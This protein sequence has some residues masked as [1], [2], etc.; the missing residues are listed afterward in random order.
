MLSF[1]GV[2]DLVT[3]AP[4][5]IQHGCLEGRSKAMLVT[6]ILYNFCWFL[7]GYLL[8]KFQTYLAFCFKSCL[9]LLDHVEAHPLR[10]LFGHMGSF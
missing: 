9:H 6:N 7:K 4:F 5:W 1:F 8:D 10:Y 2:V 3:V